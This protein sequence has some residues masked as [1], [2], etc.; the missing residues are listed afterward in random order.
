MDKIAINDIY[1]LEGKEM[2][3]HN[4]K[5]VL[6]NIGKQS[7]AVRKAVQQFSKAKAEIDASQSYR[8]EHTRAYN[9]VIYQLNGAEVLSNPA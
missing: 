7:L 3:C 5:T 8:V 2:Q 1:H 4:M 6:S 9:A